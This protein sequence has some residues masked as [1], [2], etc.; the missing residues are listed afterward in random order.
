MSW[1]VTRIEKDGR[2]LVI[3]VADDQGQIPQIILADR[4]QIDWEAG[5]GVRHDPEPGAK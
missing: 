2:E 3:G 5:Y 1:T 4:D